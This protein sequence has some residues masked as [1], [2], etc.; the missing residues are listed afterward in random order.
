MK[1]KKIRFIK[2]LDVIGVIKEIEYGNL[3]RKFLNLNNLKYI[4]LQCLNL[5]EKTLIKFGFKKNKNEIYN[6]YEPYKKFHS[7]HVVS[8]I[9]NIYKKKLYFY[10]GD[11]DNERPRIL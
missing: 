2:I 5:N 8:I 1:K 3:L 9:K 10:A 6:F 11:G 4:D 7:P